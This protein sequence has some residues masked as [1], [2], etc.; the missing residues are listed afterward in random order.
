MIV[1]EWYEEP[2]DEIIRLCLRLESLFE[3]Y[4]SQLLNPSISAS[5]HSIMTLQRLLAATERSDLKS[6]L[7]TQ[8]S[9]QVTSMMQLHAHPE[10]DKQRLN[11]LLAQME[12]DLQALRDM[13]QRFGE[14][15]RQN[16]LLNCVRAHDQSP[17]GMTVMAIPQYALWLRQSDDQR[18]SCLT[19]WMASF[20]LLSRIVTRLLNILRQGMAVRAVQAQRGYF[21][22]ALNPMEPCALLRVQLP[23]ERADVYPVMSIGKH[24]VV[25]QL[26]RITDMAQGLSQK[27]YEDIPFTLALCRL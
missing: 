15:L 6:K 25:I 24:R 22:Q 5:H 8:L 26:H 27:I 14:V 17:T 7:A 4:R 9:Q 18:T 21:E 16:Q 3:Q 20:T 12:Q 1:N 19:E 23:A 13:K 10:V 11:S 2:T